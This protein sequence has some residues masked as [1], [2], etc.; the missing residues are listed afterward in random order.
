[1]KKKTN[2][3][4]EDILRIGNLPGAASKGIFPIFK[5]NEN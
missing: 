2:K 5:E 1:M 4:F 3:K